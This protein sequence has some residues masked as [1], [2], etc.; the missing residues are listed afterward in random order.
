MYVTSTR[1]RDCLVISAYEENIGDKRAWGVLDDR[2]QDVPELE[3]PE[4]GA[5]RQVEEREEL[6][7]KKGE[8]A[9]AKKQIEEKQEKANV[10]SYGVESVTSLAKKEAER[11]EWRRGSYGMAWGR[12]VH[13]MLEIAGRW[14]GDGESDRERD[15]VGERD[16]EAVGEN[17]GAEL[18]K[19]AENILVTEELDIGKKAELVSLIESIRRSEFWE[20]VNQAEN[21]FYEVP[22]SIKTDGKTLG[23][24][25]RE[26]L[27]QTGGKE[28]AEFPII[29]NG[30]IDLVFKEDDGWVIVDFKTDDVKEELDSFVKYY[31]P[32]VELYS[33]FWAEITGENVKERGLYFTSVNEWVAI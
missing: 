16:G 33:K 30:T 5:V 6:K 11:P 23:I 22:F 26:S 2:L 9:A 12:A 32:Q 10:P 24:A 1:A 21:K 13:K 18:E 15:G 4:G 29:L 31:S 14:N 20:R 25:K 3:I 27:K 28:L 7:L 17:R 8:W 19:L